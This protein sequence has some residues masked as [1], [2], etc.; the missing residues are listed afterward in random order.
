MAELRGYFFHEPRHRARALFAGRPVLAGHNKK[1]PEPAGIIVEFL[2]PRG[3]TV[4][5]AQ[6]IHTR[7]GKH[8][9]GAIVIRDI[10][11]EHIFQI[12]RKPR[13]A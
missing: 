8:V 1:C 2:Y 12:F 6:Q 7:L 11:I 9:D 3:D 5:I 13:S 4:R 10:E